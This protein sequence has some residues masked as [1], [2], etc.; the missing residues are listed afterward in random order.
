MSLIGPFPFCSP[1]VR[2]AISV[3]VGGGSTDSAHPSQFQGNMPTTTAAVQ[4][5]TTN[6]GGKGYLQPTASNDDLFSV[7]AGV[8][9]F[10]AS[11][12]R[13]QLGGFSLCLILIYVPTGRYNII[14]CLFSFSTSKRRVETL[15]LPLRHWDSNQEN[16]VTK[17]DTGF[18]SIFPLHF[19]ANMSFA[20][21]S[22]ARS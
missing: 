10:S 19:T 4:R 21:P 13:T 5:N 9:Q 18:A 3:S 7:S 8:R 15:A 17:K 20:R 14:F 22:P 16:S 2:A 11:R 1:F 6:D 12:L